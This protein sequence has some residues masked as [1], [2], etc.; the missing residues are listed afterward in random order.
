LAGRTVLRAV[1]L[2]IQ[3]AYQPAYDPFHTVLRMIRIADFMG[4][5]PS[6]GQARIADFYLSFPRRLDDVKFPKG[7]RGRLRV[8]LAGVPPHYGAAPADETV[9]RKMRPIQDAAMQT[10]L[11][12]SSLD[13]DAFEAGTIALDLDSVSERL[14]ERARALNLEWQSLVELIRDMIAAVPLEG[15]QGLKHRTGLGEHRYDAV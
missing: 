15:V 3:L 2:V 14:L 10:L 13:N 1:A 9:L 11:G 7:M 6:V 8:A 12:N 5:P 4:T